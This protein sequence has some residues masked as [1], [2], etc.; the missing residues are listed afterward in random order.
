[1]TK[2]PQVKPKDVLK[3]VRKQ[4]LKKLTGEVATLIFII[5]IVEELQLQ[6]IPNFYLR[7]HFTKF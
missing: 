4:D 2:L 1:M 5:Q 3:A 6:F 7:E